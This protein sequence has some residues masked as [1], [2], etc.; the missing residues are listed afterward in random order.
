MSYFLHNGINQLGPFTI[1]D[2][3]KRGILS[4]TPVWKEGLKDWKKAGELDE[5][6]ELF[7][8]VPP[9]FKAESFSSIT[10]SKTVSSTEKLG[11]KLGRFLGL[12]GLL[13]IAAVIALYFYNRPYSSPRSTYSFSLPP[14][15]PEHS[16]PSQYLTASGFY[17][18]NFWGD[19]MVL[20][21][22][23]TNNATHTNYKDI[24]IKMNFFS[25]TKSIVSSQE[26]I[27]YEYVPY[28]S[29]KEFNHR[30]VKPPAAA[31]CGWEAVGGTYY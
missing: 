30:I 24:R 25:Q 28:S 31:S 6:A 23:V 4:D 9:T 26:Y 29:T 5:L 22:K 18:P 19:K 27:L 12:G 7:S 2:L 10:Q 11:Y 1:D 13:V 8:Q 3:R 17:H 20:N 16:N 15:D 21:G 14:E